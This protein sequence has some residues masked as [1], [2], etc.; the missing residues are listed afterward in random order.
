MLF[1]ELKDKSIVV[2]GFARE[3]K[4]TFL[5]LRKLF[6]EKVI[7]IADEKKVERPDKKAKIY[8]GDKYLKAVG[9]YEM[10]IKTPG[11]PLSKVRPFLKR[12][13]RVTSQTEIFFD[14]FRGKV[15]GVTG[16]KGKGT[17]ASLIYH[18]LNKGGFS[19]EL[20][21][22]IGRPV[23]QKLLKAKPSNI[24]VYELSSHQLQGLKKS[25]QI[26]VFLNIF[27]DH[28][29]YYQS[30][31]EYQKAKE[32]I[33][34][35]QRAGDWLI[36]NKDDRVVREM[37][38]KSKARKIAFSL[39]NKSKLASILSRKE[40]P[41][42]GDFNLLNVLAA[43]RVAEIFRV[44]K[45]DIAL[46]IKGFRGLPH[47]LQYIGQ[48][49]GISFYNDSMST[50]PETTIAALRALKKVKT[51]I[52]GGSDKGS[53]YTNLAKAILRASL[54]TVIVFPGTGPVIW[55][56]VVSGAKKTKQKAPQPFFANSM[57]EAVKVAFEETKKG[58]ICLLSPASAS[59]NLFKDY[60]ERGELFKKWV[61]L[62]GKKNKI[63]GG[64]REA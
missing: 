30:F 51:L 36:Y 35:Y 52:I 49:Q 1:S 26:T 9:H 50:L 55:Q 46:A 33:V 28:L 31:K 48:Y 32:S 5:A 64:E 3:G 10:V 4:D 56:E 18:I 44:S 45:K 53:D 6:P 42:K 7:A 41:L 22:N 11:I 57:E 54:R 14:N 34:K 58:E 13:A 27:P 47:R 62:Y 37:A 25:P 29:D 63:K 2:L 59:F 23:L 38:K 16:T 21:G 8:S 19:V 17:T 39:K 40:I 24:F 61:K 60:Q 43:V 12:G 15:I 20:I